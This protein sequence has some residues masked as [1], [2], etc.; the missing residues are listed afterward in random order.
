MQVSPRNPE[1]VS[2]L[3]VGCGDATEQ[4]INLSMRHP[5]SL[6]QTVGLSIH[7]TVGQALRMLVPTAM[8][9]LAVYYVR[10]VLIKFL[11]M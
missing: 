7:A 11:N 3:C 4:M 6:A 8:T 9:N 10:R 1:G 2:A 5:I